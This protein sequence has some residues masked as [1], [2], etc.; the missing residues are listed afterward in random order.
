MI[1]REGE[2]LLELLAWNGFMSSHDLH[3]WWRRK[4]AQGV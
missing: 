2:V 3:V 1:S 4:P